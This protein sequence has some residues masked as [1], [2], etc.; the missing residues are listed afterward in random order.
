MLS[1]NSKRP[2]VFTDSE[3]DGLYTCAEQAAILV[4]ILHSW[5]VIPLLGLHSFSVKPL[6]LQ[7][8]SDAVRQRGPY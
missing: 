3:V 5:K 2:R 8:W 7:Q 1:V 6:D 4:E